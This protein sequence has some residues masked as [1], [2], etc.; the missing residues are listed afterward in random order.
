LGSYKLTYKEIKHHTFSLDIKP[1]TNYN[2]EGH[3]SQGTMMT[4]TTTQQKATEGGTQEP[5]TLKKQLK[6]T[7][8]TTTGV[9]NVAESPREDSRKPLD[10]GPSQPTK[11]HSRLYL[12]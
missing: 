5:P 1:N 11:A 2:G 6:Q 10:P 3:K 7:E 8:R 12:Y 9:W 4:A